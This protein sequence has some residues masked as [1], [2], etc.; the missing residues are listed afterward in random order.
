[1]TRLTTDD[2]QDIRFELNAYDRY[3]VSATGRS[4]LGIGAA[5]AGYWR[6]SPVSRC[7]LID[8]YGRGAHPQRLLAS[9][10]VLLRRSAAS[11]STWDSMRL[12][13]DI[14]TCPVL[15][16]PSTWEPR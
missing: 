2:I 8:P 11:S 1:M 12:S 14:R 15:P 9:F 3:L 13:P 6:C 16:K 10:P 5:A 7:R 4:L